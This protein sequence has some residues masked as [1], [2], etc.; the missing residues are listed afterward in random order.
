MTP[1]SP[2]RHAWQRGNEIKGQTGLVYVWWRCGCGKRRV[3]T[4]GA[5]GRVGRRYVAAKRG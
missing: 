5:T 4:L 1:T 2:H 3:D